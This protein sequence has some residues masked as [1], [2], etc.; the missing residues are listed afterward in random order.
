MMGTEKHVLVLKYL[1]MDKIWVCHDEPELKRQSLESKY[2]N[3]LMKKKFV[4]QSVKNV[5]LTVFW[6]MKQPITINFLE[7]KVQL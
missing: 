2:T 4:Q 5:I 7:K 6:D 1:H 3:Y